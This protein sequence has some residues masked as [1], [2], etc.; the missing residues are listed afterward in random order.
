MKNKGFLLA[1]SVGI[2]FVPATG[3][4]A[5]MAPVF[6]APPAVAPVAAWEG[7]YIG[8]HGGA[9]WQQGQN[10][11]T[12]YYIAPPVTT[13][14]TSGV[15]GGQIG[16]NWQRGSYVFGVEVDGSWLGK[17]GSVR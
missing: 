3:Q 17:G 7:F 4:A 15:A 16:Y 2:A 8:V 1:S 11:F 10:T 12:G 5:D 13:T 14:S 9:A 6:K